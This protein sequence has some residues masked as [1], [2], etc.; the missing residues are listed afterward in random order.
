MHHRLNGHEFVQALG[1]GD[2]QGSLA[3][4]SPW[5]HK[6]SDMTELLSSSTLW[7]GSD[8]ESRRGEEWRVASSRGA[9]MGR[10]SSAASDLGPSEH[11]V[12]LGVGLLGSSSVIFS[13]FPPVKCWL[14]REAGWMDLRYLLWR[15]SG[16]L[17][18]A[19]STGSEA[20]G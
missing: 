20:P 4:C 15:E 9:G 7:L 18:Q 11:S 10:R 5:G 3:C 16:K 1:D 14:E 2:R 12:W 8:Q 17:S 19:T 13:P 6:E